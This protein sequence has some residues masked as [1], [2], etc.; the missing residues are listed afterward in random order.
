MYVYVN[1]APFDDPTDFGFYSMACVRARYLPEQGVKFPPTGRLRIDASVF[2]DPAEFDPA[3][4]CV[5]A[6]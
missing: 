4:D 6:R 3:L 5:E 2:V 1:E